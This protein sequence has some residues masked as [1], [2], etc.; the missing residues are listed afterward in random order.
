MNLKF[1]VEWENCESRHSDSE[2]YLIL[3]ISRYTVQHI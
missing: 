2:S 1:G 3:E